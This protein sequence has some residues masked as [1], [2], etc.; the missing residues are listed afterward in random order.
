MPQD[1]DDGAPTTPPP[2]PKPSKKNIHRLYLERTNVQCN[3]PT[4][5]K[6]VTM[7]P[8]NGTAKSIVAWAKKSKLDKRQTRAFT[9][10]VARFILTFYAEDDDSPLDEEG[11]TRRDKLEF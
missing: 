1:D 5:E 7:P 10:I 3:I 4:S 6:P 8:T 11:A 9:T 2:P